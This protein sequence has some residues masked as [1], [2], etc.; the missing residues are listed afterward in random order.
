MNFTDVIIRGIT[1]NGKPFRPSDWA[2]R[3]CGVV[4]VFEP[5]QQKVYALLV[6][7]V[8]IAGIK[9]VVVNGKL[10]QMEPRF[11]RFLLDFAH[12]NELQV[13]TKPPVSTAPAGTP[14]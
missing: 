5:A 1:A 2:E 9:C 14:S 11:F 13:T 4:G 7:Q 10:E 12:D 8:D 3:L 6:R